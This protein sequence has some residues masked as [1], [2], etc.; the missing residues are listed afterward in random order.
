MLAADLP[1]TLVVDASVGLKWVVDETGSDAAAEIIAGKRLLVPDLFWVEAANA[2]AGKVRRGELTRAQAQDAWRDLAQAPLLS[3]P[4][5]P[6]F[7]LPALG[8]AH[9]FSHPVYDCVYLALGIAENAK[10]ITADRRFVDLVRAHPY[11]S[12]KVILLDELAS[13]SPPL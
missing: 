5:T 6:D 3:I 12:D 11:F 7:L 10:V 9:D 8:L 4:T 2:L 13:A 1:N